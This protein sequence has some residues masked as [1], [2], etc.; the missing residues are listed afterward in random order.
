MA[1]KSS[2]RNPIAPP[3]KYTAVPITDPKRIAELEAKIERYESAANSSKKRNVMTWVRVRPNRSMQCQVLRSERKRLRQNSTA[4][5]PIQNGIKHRKFPEFLQAANR[6]SAKMPKLD[7]P[8]ACPG[9][10]KI[11]V[12][13][14]TA[15]AT[16]P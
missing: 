6:E 16:P 15:N 3:R 7:P 12:F 4:Q 5:P 9:P 10:C 13:L 8:L 2:N 1:S 11:P 14:H